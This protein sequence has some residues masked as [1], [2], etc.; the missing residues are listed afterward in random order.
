MIIA[1]VMEVLVRDKIANTDYSTIP[2]PSRLDFPSCGRGVLKKRLY[3]FG[4]CL[5]GSNIFDGCPESLQSIFDALELGEPF[6]PEHYGQESPYFHWSGINRITAY[7]L[8]VYAHQGF[9]SNQAQAVHVDGTLQEIGRIKTSIIA[10]VQPSPIGG[11]SILFNSTA[12]FLSILRQNRKYAQALLDD[13]ALTRTDIGRTGRSYTGPVFSLRYDEIFTRFSLDNT[14]TW[15]VDEVPFLEEAKAALEKMLLN[16]QF[17]LSHKL[18]ENEIL[19]LLNSKISHGRNKFIDTSESQRL[20]L[21][22]LFECNP[23]NRNA[24]LGCRL[25]GLIA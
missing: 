2:S 15:N 3:S 19:I 9:T 7:Q 18:E 5:I 10:C 6:V 25:L 20:L 1:N 4:F 8:S 17:A 14:C 21:R 12:A 23:L 24:P 11:E 22:A 16:R 13:R